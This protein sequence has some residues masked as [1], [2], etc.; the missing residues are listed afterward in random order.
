MANL[1]DIVRKAGTASF[2]IGSALGGKNAIASRITDKLALSYETG[3][4]PEHQSE[5]AEQAAK[6]IT[7]DKF[8]DDLQNRIGTPQSGE[9][10]EIFVSRA[11]ERMRALLRERLK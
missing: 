9:T 3:I 10:E 1:K 5:F 4:S 11:K 7:E 6:L 8:L 2:A